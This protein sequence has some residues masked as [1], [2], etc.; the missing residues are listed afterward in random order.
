MLR[1][2]CGNLNHMAK[3][4]ALVELYRQDKLTQHELGEALGLTRLETDAVLK[5]HNVT[6]DLPTDTEL[7]EGLSNLRR[8][9]GT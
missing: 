5:N 1:E 4:A 9:L 8:L 3:E 7:A 2:E 6:E